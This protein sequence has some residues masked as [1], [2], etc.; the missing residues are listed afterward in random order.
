MYSYPFCRQV[1]AIGCF[2][3]LFDKKRGNAYIY[4]VFLT[5]QMDIVLKF[6][7]KGILWHT[8]IHQT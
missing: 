8:G 4:L 3:L 1:P 2:Y 7:Q 6:D 5:I